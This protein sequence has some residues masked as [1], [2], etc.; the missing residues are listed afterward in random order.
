MLMKI[1]RNL[2]NYDVNRPSGKELNV[3]NDLK[4]LLEKNK[5]DKRSPEKSSSIDE[6]S[7]INFV[8]DKNNISN[9]SWGKN[10][11]PI[12]RSLLSK[13]VYNEKVVLKN[14]KAENFQQYMTS[15]ARKKE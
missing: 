7:P 4:V 10:L 2:S 1:S 14:L 6:P 3:L 5:T 12:K 9:V 8:A 13:V 15:K 11:P